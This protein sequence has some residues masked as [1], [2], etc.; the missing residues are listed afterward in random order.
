MHSQ[1]EVQKA[2]NAEKLKHEALK[3]NLC[4]ECGSK[5]ETTSSV[6]ETKKIKTSFWGKKTTETWKNINTYKQCS[7]SPTHYKI[8]ITFDEDNYI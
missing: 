5:L 4:P 8:A 3:Y 2:I 7:N 6:I 1:N